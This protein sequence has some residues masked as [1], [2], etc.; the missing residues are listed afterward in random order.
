MR[1]SGLISYGVRRSRRAFAQSSCNDHLC[2][3]SDA[4]TVNANSPPDTREDSGGLNESLTEPVACPNIMGALVPGGGIPSSTL[5]MASCVIFRRS[6]KPRPYV[7]HLPAGCTLF[8]FN[9]GTS[10]KCFGFAK[11]YLSRN[12]LPHEMNGCLLGGSSSMEVRGGASCGFNR[13]FHQ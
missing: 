3:G 11:D 8:G 4:L 7:N 6:S 13:R 2:V 1:S 9:A 12:G 10:S 5:G